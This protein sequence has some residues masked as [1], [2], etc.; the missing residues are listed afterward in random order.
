[1]GGNCGVT[2]LDGPLI[3]LGARSELRST[4]LTVRISV[5]YI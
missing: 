2:A 5:A 3:I 1:M 4:Q